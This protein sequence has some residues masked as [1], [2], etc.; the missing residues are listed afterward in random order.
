MLEAQGDTSFVLGA[1]IQHTYP[2]VVGRSS[3]HTS[4]EALALGTAEI[5]RIGRRLESEGR[6]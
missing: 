4:R 3:V 2:L 1:A 6:I 5:D